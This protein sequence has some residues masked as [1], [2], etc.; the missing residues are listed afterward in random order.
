VRGSD[1][2]RRILLVDDDFRL[3]G[4]LG[5]RLARDG[6]DCVVARTGPDALR[7]LDMAWPDLILLDLMLPGIDGVELAGEIKK[8]A[9]IPIIIVSAID[10]AESKVD[11]L[12]R[13]AEDYVTKPFD[14]D[15]LLARIQRVLRRTGDRIP[16]QSLTLGPGLTLILPRREAMRD[17]E[18]IGL[19]RTEARLLATLAANLGEP[20]STEA[21]LSRVWS[22]ADGADPA[23]V[24]V[25]VR[26]LRR[27]IERDPDA[28]RHLLTERLGGYR[29]VRDEGAS[30]G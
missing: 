20:V 14:F 26:R 13:Y 1:R 5:D 19:S 2:R 3:A 6:Y 8:R 16:S 11:L 30:G 24:W 28:P 7:R 22:D 12:Q 21:I 27:K 18:R 17:G 29:L 4:L 15:E 23:Y 25:T 10:E 9:D